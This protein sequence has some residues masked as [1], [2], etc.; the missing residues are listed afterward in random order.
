ML[1]CPQYI[2]QQVLTNY[3]KRGTT[4]S[5]SLL[6]WNIYCDTRTWKCWSMLSSI[7]LMAFMQ[8][9]SNTMGWNNVLRIFFLLLNFPILRGPYF[10][11]SLKLKPF[12]I[13]LSIDIFFSIWRLT[14][15]TTSTDNKT[16]NGLSF[17]KIKT[18]FYG[19][20]RLSQLYIEWTFNH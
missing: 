18:N 16:G 14:E 3:A 10:L 8:H 11:Q 19:L 1:L 6:S 2:A 7:Q 9:L 15:I 5:K 12:D 17:S 13:L 4:G 20:L